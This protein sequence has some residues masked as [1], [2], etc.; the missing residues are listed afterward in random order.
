MAVFTHKLIHSTIQIKELVKKKK[1]EGF[2]I[3]LLGSY[4][5]L[6]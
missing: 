6:N 5:S 4:Y 3:S 2:Q 1:T